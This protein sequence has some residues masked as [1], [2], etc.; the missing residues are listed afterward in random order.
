M[1]TVVT[2]LI[3]LV[4]LLHFGFMVLEM[5]LWTKPFGLKIFAQNLNQAKSSAVLAANQGLYNGFLATGLFWSVLHT[6][7][8][9]AMELQYFFLSC[10]LI[11]G[12][13][14]GI[15][16]SKKIALVQAVPAAS[17]ILLSLLK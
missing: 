15:T 13:Y 8:P 7:P 16:V 3:V 17:A 12:I 4:A 11:A 2:V 9:V 10:V 14:G 6:S 5:F 1:S